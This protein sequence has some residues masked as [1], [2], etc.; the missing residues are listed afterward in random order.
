M[1]NW[2]VITT[3]TTTPTTRTPMGH[4]SYA[5][6][7]MEVMNKMEDTIA[8]KVG[9]REDREKK[10]CEPYTSRERC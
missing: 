8:Q 2:S 4:V 10:K 7:P 1:V 5:M 6:S 3:A 9:I